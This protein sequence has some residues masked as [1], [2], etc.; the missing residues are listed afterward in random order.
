MQTSSGIGPHTGAILA[1]CNLV[2]MPRSTMLYYMRAGIRKREIVVYSDCGDGSL[3]I[4]IRD[5]ILLDV[6]RTILPTKISS[7]IL[8]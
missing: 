2:S 4:T 1:R 7:I 8:W 5:N 3:Y 6:L